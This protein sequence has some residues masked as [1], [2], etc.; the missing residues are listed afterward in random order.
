M[1]KTNKSI[2]WFLKNKDAFNISYVA[3]ASGIPHA[4]LDKWGKGL[5]PLSDKS[6]ELLKVWVK[7]FKK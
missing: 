2:S 3:K 7:E 4:S 5:R 6:Q 1:N